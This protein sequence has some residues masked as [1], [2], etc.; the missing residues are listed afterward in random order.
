MSCHLREAP[1]VK[2]IPHQRI[3][4]CCMMRSSAYPACLRTLHAV[5]TCPQL[6]QALNRLFSLTLS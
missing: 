3:T 6:L 5:A 1:V 2:E 4:N